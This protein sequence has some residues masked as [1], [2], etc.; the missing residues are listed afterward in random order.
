M[1]HLSKRNRLPPTTL[2]IYITYQILFPFFLIFGLFQAVLRNLKEPTH[3]RQLADR[4]GLGPIGPKDAIWFYAASLGEMNAARPL[5]QIFLDNGHNILLTHLSPAGLEAGKRFFNTYP[6]VTHRYMPFDFFL[7]VQIFLRRARPAC[8]IVLEV[9]IW[10]AM[11]IEAD[12]LGIPMFMAN[13]NLSA[14]IMPRLKT[15]KRSGLHMYRLFDHI[16]TRAQDYVDRYEA[17]GVSLKDLTITGELRLDTPRNL[18]SIEKGKAWRKAWAGRQFT[19]MISSSVQAEE[20]ALMQCCVELSKRVPKMRVI[21]V[22][23]SP[24]RFEPIRQ[25]AINANLVSMRRSDLKSII[26]NTIQLFIGNSMGEMDLY[27][28]MADVVFVGAS[29]NNLGGHNIVEPLTAGCPVVMGPSTYGVDFIAKDAAAAGIFK[30]FSSPEKM[31]IFIEDIAKSPKKLRQLRLAT[32]TFF[33]MPTRAA[34]KC[35]RVIN[36]YS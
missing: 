28:G 7:M 21:W 25:K 26:P 2:L 9:E 17:V 19:F 32:S 10:P 3:L 27:L 35:Y 22:P 13:G 5:V 4:F 11:L 16:F 30:S 1:K 6:Q 15:W 36:S 14:K 18:I 33:K 24:Q 29:F 20:N 23:R 12:R 34:E 31:T 8:G